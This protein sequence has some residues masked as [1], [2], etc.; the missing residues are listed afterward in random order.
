MKFDDD[1]IAKNFVWLQPLL[2]I[3]CCAIGLTGLVLSIQLDQATEFIGP[4]LLWL[5][6]L[7]LIPTSA[8]LLWWTSQQFL[9]EGTRHIPQGRYSDIKHR[10]TRDGSLDWLD[11]WKGTVYRM[12]R[13]LTLLLLALSIAATAAWAMQLWLSGN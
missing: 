4:M 8:A 3:G 2:L 11:S 10:A 1:F 9:Q 13:T 5:C 7:A 6:V 12:L